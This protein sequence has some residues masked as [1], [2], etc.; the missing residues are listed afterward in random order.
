MN[1]LEA[2]TLSALRD[3]LVLKAAPPFREAAE[4]RTYIRH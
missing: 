1:N 2:R 4:S 3:T